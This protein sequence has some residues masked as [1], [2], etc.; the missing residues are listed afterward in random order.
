MTGSV[1][2]PCITGISEV[3]ETG[4]LSLQVAVRVPDYVNNSS[5]SV[6]FTDTVGEAIY[7]NGGEQVVAVPVDSVTD[8]AQL[9]SP[10][11]EGR[12]WVGFEANPVIST[13]DTFSALEYYKVQFI[14]GDV[15]EEVLD[16]A[17]VFALFGSEADSSRYA[18]IVCND[19][20]FIPISGGWAIA[21]I[22]LFLL[23]T[24]AITLRKHIRARQSIVKI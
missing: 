14:V 16:T 6:L 5:V 15:A 17:R 20:R 12:K 18:V 1:I 10:A 13:A 22:L 7:T 23:A 3:N 4:M 11:P 8:K 19:S 21:V 24:G 2:I 9:C